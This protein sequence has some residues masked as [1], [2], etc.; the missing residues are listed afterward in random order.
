MVDIISEQLAVAVSSIAMAVSG[1]QWRWAV[2][3]GSG[4]DRIYKMNKIS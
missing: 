1:G 4:L 2:A 3:V